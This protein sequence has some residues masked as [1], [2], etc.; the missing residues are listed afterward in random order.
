MFSAASIEGT[1]FCGAQ[2]LCMIGQPIRMFSKDSI[3][4]WVCRKLMHNQCGISYTVTTSTKR[5]SKG[6]FS[7]SSESFRICLD[8]LGSNTL[9]ELVTNILRSLTSYSTVSGMETKTI[10]TNKKI[11]LKQFKVQLL[12]Q[13]FKQIHQQQGIKLFAVFE[14]KFRKICSWVRH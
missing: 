13:D 2:H 4:C 1:Q 3:F 6:Q 11:L 10:L 14:T 12:Q 8:C 7:N 9:E 5:V